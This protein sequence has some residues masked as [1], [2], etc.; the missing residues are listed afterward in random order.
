[1][2]YVEG[3]MCNGVYETEDGEMEE[4]VAEEMYKDERW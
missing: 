3:K 2:R 1:M 4:Y